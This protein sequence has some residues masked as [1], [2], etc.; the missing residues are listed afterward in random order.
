MD[1]KRK[2]FPK[3]LDGLKKAIAKNKYIALVLILGLAIILWPSGGGDNGEERSRD[4]PIIAE[5]QMTPQFS[6][7]QEE[8]R[9][10]EALSQIAGAGRVSVVLTLR[11]SVEQE[12]AVDEDSS[13]RRATVTIATGQGTQSEVTLRYNYPRYQGALVIS[14]GANDA[15]VRLEITR[16][17]A[18]LTGLRTDHITV[19]QMSPNQASSNQIN[20]A[21]QWED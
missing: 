12:V 7:A 3:G 2:G 16:A 6:L 19:S 17:V 20:T 18:A 5:E 14:E 21:Y 4:A 8:A 10:A 11:T 1:E 15:T 13:G 9:I